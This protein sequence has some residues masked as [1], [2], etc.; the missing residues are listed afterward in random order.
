MDKKEI[1]DL[2]FPPDYDFTDVEARHLV[3]TTDANKVRWFEVLL[4]MLMCLK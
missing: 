2:I 4:Y 3:N 1:Q